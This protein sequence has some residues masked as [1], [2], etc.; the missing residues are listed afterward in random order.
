M[1]REHQEEHI[2]SRTTAFK[3]GQLKEPL[4][5]ALGILLNYSRN[6][7]Y[8]YSYHTEMGIPLERKK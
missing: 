3:L 2:A 6:S 1:E 8:L 5:P 7:Y 4:K